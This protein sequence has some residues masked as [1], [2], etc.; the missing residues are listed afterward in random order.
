MTGVSGLTARTA[1]TAKTY[2]DIHPRR[3][4]E[5][6]DAIGIQ[7]GQVG[8]PLVGQH[9]VKRHLTKARIRD[10]EARYPSWTTAMPPIPYPHRL[11][12][13][14]RNA[15][16]G[17]RPSP[18]TYSNGWISTARKSWLSCTTSASPSTW[19]NGTFA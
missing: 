14:E 19:P 5:A 2:Y 17:K 7:T 3:G 11:P 12:L 9:Q 1:S 13:P 18:G 8:H 4:A 6:L 16:G 10:F 15:G